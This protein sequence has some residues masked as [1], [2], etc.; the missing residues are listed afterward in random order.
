MEN[1]IKRIIKE[2][3]KT[4]QPFFLT[5]WGNINNSRYQ[6][7][8]GLIITDRHQQMRVDFEKC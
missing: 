1:S 3:W 7:S 5:F 4:Q 8:R 2:S 6:F